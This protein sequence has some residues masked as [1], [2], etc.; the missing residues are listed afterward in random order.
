[1][2]VAGILLAA[3]ASTRFGSDKRRLVLPNGLRLIEQSLLNLMPVVETTFVVVAKRESWLD[4]ML[5]P[6]SSV[7]CV[8]IPQ[9]KGLGDSISFAIKHIEKEIRPNAVLLALADMP[10]IKP[11]TYTAIRKH[12]ES[13]SIVAP[14]YMGNR[15]HPVGF[16]CLYFDHLKACKGDKG[17]RMILNRECK[18]D[19]FAEIHV[20][21]AGILL[22][23]DTPD[24]DQ[25]P[26]KPC[27]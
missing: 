4:A 14:T 3:G 6:L 9:T 25:H 24:W 5:Q 12:L 22:D 10:S 11:E 16:G 2:N 18:T 19:E 20:E 17:A 1:V 7:H 26:R 27:S 15:G 8:V 23:I 13:F 21:D